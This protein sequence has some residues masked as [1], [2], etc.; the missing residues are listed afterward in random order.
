MDSKNINNVEP[1]AKKPYVAPTMVAVPVDKQISLSLKSIVVHD[2]TG[3]VITFSADGNSFSAN[4][5]DY[6]DAS[7][8]VFNKSGFE[9]ALR[10]LFMAE[11]DDLDDALDAWDAARNG[12]KE[13]QEY[14]TNLGNA[15]WTTKNAA[16]DPTSGVFGAG[17][18][19]GS[20]SSP[21]GN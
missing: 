21:F 12:N 17:D 7:T 6:L 5:A 2:V 11:Y 10:K 4:T 20:E 15:G 3:A 19:W 9:K 14:L 18:A 13:Y 8:S 1:R 16:V